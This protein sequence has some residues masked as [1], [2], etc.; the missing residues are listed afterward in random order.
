MES[1]GFQGSLEVDDYDLSA[2]WG[3][4]LQQCLQAQRKPKAGF[5]RGGVGVGSCCQMSN[6]KPEGQGV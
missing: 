2:P 6:E 1:I 3:N 5:K 4:F